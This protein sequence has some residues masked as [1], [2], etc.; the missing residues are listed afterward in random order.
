MNTYELSNRQR[1]ELDRANL[2][3]IAIPCELWLM[4]SVD[5]DLRR[6]FCERVPEIAPI[7][8][9]KVDVIEAYCVAPSATRAFDRDTLGNRLG[10]IIKPE[11]STFAWVVMAVVAKVAKH[12]NTKSNYPTQWAG[13]EIHVENETKE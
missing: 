13:G 5:A 12:K 1:K 3:S 11:T 8:V 9:A 4:D 2:M 10:G 6:Y 7:Q